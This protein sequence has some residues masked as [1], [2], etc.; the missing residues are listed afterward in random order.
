M[1]TVAHKYSATEGI[2]SMSIS[3]ILGPLLKEFTMRQRK[4]KKQRKKKGLARH[5]GTPGI[6]R[7]EFKASLGYRL[8]KTKTKP[9]QE[10]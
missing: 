5:V 6:M 1:F 7:P 3:F 2:N 9:N 4:R 10:I 8:K